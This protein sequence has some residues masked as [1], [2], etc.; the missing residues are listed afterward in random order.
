MRHVVAAVRLG[1][2][3]SVDPPILVEYNQV[4]GHMV[5]IESPGGLLA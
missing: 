5:A 3:C 4:G 1:D 2:Y